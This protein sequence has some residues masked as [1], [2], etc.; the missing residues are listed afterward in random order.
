M[1]EDSTFV[2]WNNIS[3]TLLGDKYA[4]METVKS[5]GNI[6]MHQTI[7]Q[8][9]NGLPIVSGHRRFSNG[10]TIKVMIQHGLRTMEVFAPYG[11]TLEP[12][13]RRRVAVTYVPAI[14]VYIERGWNADS[15]GLVL[16]RGG[17]FNPP[18]ELHMKDDLEEGHWED[19]TPVVDTRFWEDKERGIRYEDLRPAGVTCMEER[20]ITQPRGECSVTTTGRND[21]TCSMATPNPQPGCAANMYLETM[22]SSYTKMEFTEFVDRTFGLVYLLP[23]ENYIEWDPITVSRQ[24]TG[25]FPNLTAREETYYGGP[26]L[27]DHQITGTLTIDHETIPYHEYV[28]FNPGYPFYPP[29]WNLP[30][31]WSIQNDS[32]DAECVDRGLT[33]EGM[34]AQLRTLFEAEFEH[35]DM[36]GPDFIL[37]FSPMWNAFHPGMKFPGTYWTEYTRTVHHSG[38]NSYESHVQD[39]GNYAIIYEQGSHDTHDYYRFDWPTHED[40]LSQIHTMGGGMCGNHDEFDWNWKDPVEIEESEST[41][42]YGPTILCVNNGT[43]FQLQGVHDEQYNRILESGMVRYFEELG[44][45]GVFFIMGKVDNEYY[46]SEYIYATPTEMIRTVMDDHAWGWSRYDIT[47]FELEGVTTKNDEGETVQL[48]GGHSLRLVKETETIAEKLNPY[49]GLWEELWE[50]L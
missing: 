23:S 19:V 14:S 1:S 11:G 28:P 15:V 9:V 12:Q 8:N 16:C 20:D 48:Y 17:G 33:L 4:A 40:V 7:E 46:S 18:Y 27:L 36:Y 50:E 38:V 42:S 37:K 41:W 39:A 13:Y 5:D 49:T 21:V 44:G 32:H 31:H 26:H 35:E 10:T 22:I 24:P 30:Q 45:V 25:E 29:L 43:K 2:N 34:E 47:S 3:A 6:L